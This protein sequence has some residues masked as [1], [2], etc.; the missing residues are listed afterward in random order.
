MRLNFP[1]KIDFLGQSPHKNPIIFTFLVI[2]K[3]C[4]FWDRS[5][6]K[7]LVFKSVLDR[8]QDH[9]SFLFVIVRNIGWLF[10]F[11]P[12]A[13]YFLIFK[14]SNTRLLNLIFG[15]FIQKWCIEQ[16]DGTDSTVSKCSAYIIRHT[17]I[18]H[19]LFIRYQAGMVYGRWDWKYKAEFSYYIKDYVLYF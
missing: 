7:C 16:G 11:S 19:H 10:F 1:H 4:S 9:V 12:L 18:W 15:K 8:T 13:G 14:S 3:V 6:R 2:S 5:L 17:F